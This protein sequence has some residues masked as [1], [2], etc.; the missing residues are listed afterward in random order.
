MAARLAFCCCCA[1]GARAVYTELCDPVAFAGGA[2]YA[3][4]YSLGMD[5][6]EP[7]I[8]F[9]GAHGNAGWA[10]LGVRRANSYYGM[11]LLDIVGIDLD[12]QQVTDYNAMTAVQGQPTASAATLSKLDHLNGTLW[13]V[14][15]QLN[16][17]VDTLLEDGGV[18]DVA[19]AVGVGAIADGAGHTPL[20]GGRSVEPV[21]I[22]FCPAMR[23][24]TGLS[25]LSSA[26]SEASEDS[27]SSE[28][29][30]SSSTLSMPPATPLPATAAPPTFV[31]SDKV[32]RPPLSSQRLAKSLDATICMN[33]PSARCPALSG[34]Q[35]GAYC[36]MVDEYHAGLENALRTDFNYSYASAVDAAF[37]CRWDSP[38][39]CADSCLVSLYDLTPEEITT[40]ATCSETPAACPVLQQAGLVAK[41][42]PSTPAPITPAPLWSEIALVGAVRTCWA[43]R[44]GDCDSSA[45]YADRYCTMTP[46]AVA[47]VHGALVADMGTQVAD[48]LIRGPDVRCDYSDPACAEK[49]GV[50]ALGVQV[51]KAKQSKYVHPVGFLPMQLPVR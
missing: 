38:G 21:T 11:G 48:V 36:L 20:A 3:G 33:V 45:G 28:S 43:T 27:S 35:R 39:V 49:A 44:D 37:D 7:A 30:G 42:P 17:G 15:R 26:S 32:T 1:A 47:R 50:C 40:L 10:A 13:A 25:S 24:G 16:N 29:D 46:T 12:T 18:Y 4:G 8:R 23:T 2:P 14:V 34:G 9:H 5:D 22:L 6:G 51:P 19:R 31:P 41:L